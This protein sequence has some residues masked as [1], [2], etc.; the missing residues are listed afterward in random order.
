[1]KIG[2]YDPDFGALRSYT[3]GYLYHDDHGNPSILV[4]PHHRLT[5]FWSAHDGSQLYYRTS[6]RPAD[7][8]R[9]GPVR[10]VISHL[11]GRLG[12]TYPNPVL[13]PDE[14]N[15]VYLFWRG[16]DWGQDYATRAP[17]GHWGAAHQLVSLP[18]QRPYVKVDSDGHD[19]IGLAFTNGHPR[20][21]ITSIYYAA[22]RH[23]SLWH[24][25][26][27]WISR[28]DHAPIAPGQ[29]DLVYDG[30]RTGVSGWVWDVGFDSRRRPVI[31]YATFP[32]TQNHAY[33]YA[34]LNG[35][36]W[37]SHFLTL[38]GPT[39][40]P[41]TIEGQ[42]SGGIAL[43]HSDP[44]IVYLS[45]KVGGRFQIERWA[46]RNG[47]YSW[48]HAT[49]VRNGRD[50]LRPVVPRHAGGRRPGL[51]WLVGY[52]GSYTSYRTSIAFMR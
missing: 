23:G 24:A 22:Y 42:Y 37:V 12:F 20:E 40:S 30:G 28:L 5:V 16:A 13:L 38:A 52:Y 44:S 10:R 21:R 29:A 32:T 17:S 48:R 8:R 14:G 47:G 43:D 27:S 25:G 45:K 1:M 9:W 41:A 11:P 39:I 7:I 34:A 31:V 15:K 51:L 50:N 46:T 36:R 19:T 3:L 26:G 2:S 33:W 4:E 18:G 6:R 49:V 35:R